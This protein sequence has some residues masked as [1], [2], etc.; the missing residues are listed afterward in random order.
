MVAHH[1]HRTIVDELAHPV[2]DP[3]GVGTVADE[4]AEE[5]VALRALLCRMCEHRLDRFAV[6]VQVGDEGELHDTMTNPV[7]P[8]LVEGPRSS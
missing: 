8:E 1:R 5:G 6:G 7:R 4:V 3:S 2:D